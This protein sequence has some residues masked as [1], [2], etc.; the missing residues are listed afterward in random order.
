[1]KILS[2]ASAIPGQSSSSA[3]IETRLQLEPGWIDRRT[4]I[5]QRPTAMATE[6][7]SDLA[8]KA[9]AYLPSGC[10]SSGKNRSWSRIDLVVTE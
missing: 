8:V 6:A 10:P 4:G 2:A 5:Q 3:E 7:T 9:G 1:M